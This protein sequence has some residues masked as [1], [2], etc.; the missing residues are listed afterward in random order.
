MDRA[1]ALILA[2]VNSLQESIEIYDAIIDNENEPRIRRL[3]AQTRKDA[4]Q[5]FIHTL[6][7]HGTITATFITER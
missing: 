2:I 1:D 4:V 3:L 5:E 7:R 6:E